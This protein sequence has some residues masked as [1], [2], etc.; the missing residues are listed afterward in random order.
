LAALAFMIM[1]MLLSRED[2]LAGVP[3]LKKILKEDT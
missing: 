3:R 1:E 2:L